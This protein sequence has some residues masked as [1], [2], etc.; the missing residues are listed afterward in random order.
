MP[1]TNMEVENGLLEVGRPFSTTNRWFSTSMLVPGR[2]AEIKIPES[3]H[4]HYEVH[5]VPCI[6]AS[7]PA[8]AARAWHGRFVE[9]P[10]PRA[11]CGMLSVVFRSRFMLR[12]LHLRP[13]QNLYKPS[14]GK[15]P[16]VSLA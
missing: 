10:P 14:G 4:V 15:Q 5:R 8:T 9:Q 3:R 6:C 1:G 7:V 16:H 13:M 11:A 12:R 2:V